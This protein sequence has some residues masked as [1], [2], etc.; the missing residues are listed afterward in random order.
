MQNS[1][2]TVFGM[3]SGCT[4]A[5]RNFPAYVAGGT[6]QANVQRGVIA[7]AKDALSG[8]L[9][10]GAV[11]LCT[12]T[13]S[14][15]AAVHPPVTLLTAQSKSD[16][17]VAR[18]LPPSQNFKESF[19]PGKTGSGYA[20][21]VG[22]GYS[23]PV[24]T[25]CPVSRTC[26]GT[27]VQNSGQ[28]MRIAQPPKDQA[29]MQLAG[30]P[31]EE[32]PEALEDEMGYAAPVG[33]GYATPVKTACPVPRTCKSTLVQNSGQ[34][35]RT[36]Q[37]PKEQASMQ[38]AG[39][40]KVEPLQALEKLQTDCASGMSP[41][42]P[43][44]ACRQ[45]SEKLCSEETSP[46]SSSGLSTQINGSRAECYLQEDD[47]PTVVFLDVD[48]VLHAVNQSEHFQPKCMEALVKILHAS[49]ASV[50]L[51]SSW[52]ALEDSVIRV[53]EAL[54]AY[55]LNAIIDCTPRLFT[56]REKEICAWLD[57]HAE[58]D[59]RWIAIDDV[60]LALN[61]G[62]EPCA[63]R[64]QDHFVHTDSKSGLTEEDVEEALRLIAQQESKPAAS[65]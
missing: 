55:G 57:A 20:A 13:F 59:V 14:L 64:M 15:P 51:S 9:Q 50:V 42:Q 27:L 54:A 2:G 34:K 45:P 24:K 25:A 17:K 7:S 21:T 36:A 33:S 56:C 26:E 52:R 61:S 11:Q 10:N 38:M 53:N 6:D 23:T 48:G 5:S 62:V 43:F 37:P 63:S 12:P 47:A 1:S 18:V 60:N 4:P 40:P 3:S 8:S 44:N 22:S 32:P 31:K 19:S 46:S 58:E 65:S 29:F 49:N 39:F 28:K 16:A 30:F 41:V 35:M